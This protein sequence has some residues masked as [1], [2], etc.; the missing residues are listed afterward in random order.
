MRT[1]LILLFLALVALLTLASLVSAAPNVTTLPW[2][3]LDGGG[4]ASRGGEYSLSG[5]IGQ[6]E[7]GPRISGGDLSLQG[8]FWGVVRS[9]S[10]SGTSGSTIF[11]PLL[12]R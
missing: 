7:A 4:A 3:T 6:P 12:S 9:G 5:T 10:P 1:K 8:G 2:W 11:L